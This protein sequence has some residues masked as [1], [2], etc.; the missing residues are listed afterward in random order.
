MKEVLTKS[1]IAPFSWE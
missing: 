1:G